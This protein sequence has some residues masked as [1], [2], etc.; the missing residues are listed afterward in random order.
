[1][2]NLSQVMVKLSCVTDDTYCRI[3]NTLQSV[4]NRLRG[5][6]KYSIALVNAGGHECVN[7]CGAYRVILNKD[8]VGGQARVIKNKGQRQMRLCRHRR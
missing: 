7:K 6:G 5:P 4:S 2:Q 3:H 1:M 8:D